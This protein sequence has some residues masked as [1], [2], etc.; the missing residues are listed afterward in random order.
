MLGI[1]IDVRDKWLINRFYFYFFKIFILIEI[2][3]I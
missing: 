1:V 2:I 3:G